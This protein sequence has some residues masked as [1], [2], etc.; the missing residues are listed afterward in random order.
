MTV[1]TELCLEY[2][3]KN[4]PNCIAIEGD[5]SKALIARY[6]GSTKKIRPSYVSTYCSD[7]F[8]TLSTHTFF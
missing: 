2:T 4:H 3:T 5:H 8:E 1:F 6:S 7:T